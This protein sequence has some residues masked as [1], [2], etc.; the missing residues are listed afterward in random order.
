[1]EATKSRSAWPEESFCAWNHGRGDWAMD[2][3]DAGA[4]EHGLEAVLYA[5][6]QDGGVAEKGDETAQVEIS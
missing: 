2:A 5:Q 4:L 1:M 6:W 3:K